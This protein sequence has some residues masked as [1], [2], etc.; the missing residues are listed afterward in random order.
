MVYANTPW[1]VF[2]PR[3]SAAAAMLY[4]ATFPPRRGSQKPGYSQSYT[5]SMVKKRRPVTKSQSLKSLVKATEPAKHYTWSNNASLVHNTLLTC[6]P[7]QGI[8][9]GLT[10]TNRLGDSVYLCAV[11][12]HGFYQSASTA[13]AYTF[14]LQVGWTG[15]EYGTANIAGQ[16]VSGLTLAEVYLP[17]T[18]AL[19][20]VNGITNP[21][22]FT[23]L[24]D[25]TIDINSQ[26][27]A[28]VDVQSFEFTVPLNVN[29][30][31]QSDGSVFGKARNLVVVASASVASGVSGTTA[32]GNVVWSGDLIFK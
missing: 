32:S 29:F 18:A 16:L 1:N 7:S 3:K 9:Q 12:I 10:N 28:T 21:K 15:E 11:K 8:A 2:N 24:Y 20:S 13:N 17:N 27:A 31:Y 5:T 22:A 30:P 14:R 19:A 23:S 4:G 25:L 26:L 6:A